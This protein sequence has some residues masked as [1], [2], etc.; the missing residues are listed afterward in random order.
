MKKLV[1]TTLLAIASVATS[2]A[3][4]HTANY[5]VQ[6]SFQAEFKGANNV[7]WTACGNLSKA[8][9][10]LDD[11]KAEAFFNADGLMIAV[12]KSVSLSELPIKAKRNFAKKY[13]GY[14][15]TDAIRFESTDECAY[16][17]YAD[18]GQDHVMLKVGDSK[19]LVAVK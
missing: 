18:N 14:T 17:M 2:F 7:T 11:Q 15:V 13:E 6:N 12:S 5:F 3:D 19:N 9:F 1:F 16:Y 8:S 10:T 4:T